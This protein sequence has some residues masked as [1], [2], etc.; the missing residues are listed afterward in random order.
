[1]SD[2]LSLSFF[3]FF[4]GKL[5]K[6]DSGCWAGGGR[7]EAGETGRDMKYVKNTFLKTKKVRGQ[8][9]QLL[10]GGTCGFHQG[11]HA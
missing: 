7:L 3:F 2:F 9:P 8:F 4:K 1:M 10:P 5:R 6:R 11:N